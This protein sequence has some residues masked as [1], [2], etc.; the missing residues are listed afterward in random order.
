MS[1]EEIIRDTAYAIWEAEGKPVGR[2]VD[3]WRQAE[4]RVAASLA[5]APVA[6]AAKPKTAPRAAPA[7]AKRKSS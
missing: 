1:R 2:D 3:H 5:G 4:E 7:A 6:K